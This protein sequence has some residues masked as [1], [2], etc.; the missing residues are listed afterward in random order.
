MNKK[1]TFVIICLI[2]ISGVIAYL[3]IMKTNPKVLTPQVQGYD[4]KE[5]CVQKTG[6]SCEFDC[7]GP[8]T[9]GKDVTTGSCNFAKWIPIN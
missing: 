1:L 3:Q 6:K 4:S 9:Y 2:I 7:G 5:E 8:A